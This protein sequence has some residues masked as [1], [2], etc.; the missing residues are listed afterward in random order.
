MAIQTTQL[1]AIPDYTTAQKIK[2]VDA[3]II[4][5]LVAGQSN[6]MSG[7]SILRAQL[8]DLR[9]LRA[10]LVADGEAEEAAAT[11]SCGGT[12]LVQYG[13]RV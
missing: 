1:D 11:G 2:A 9:E 10:E 12:A 4:A 13:E 6:G 7:S 3:A 8:K 5:V